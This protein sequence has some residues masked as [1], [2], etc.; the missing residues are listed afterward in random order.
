MSKQDEAGKLND[1]EEQL[2]PT[3]WYESDPAAF[4]LAEKFNLSSEACS[5]CFV[6]LVFFMHRSKK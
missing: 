2:L 4:K 6:S 5:N 1:R 3:P